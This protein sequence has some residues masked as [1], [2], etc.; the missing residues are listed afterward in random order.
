MYEEVAAWIQWKCHSWSYLQWSLIVCSWTALGFYIARYSEIARIDN[1]FRQTRGQVYIDLQ[2]LTSINATLNS[3]LG[4]CCFFASM[5][6]LSFSRYARRL[7]IFGDAL[8]SATKELF[9]FTCLFLVMFTAFLVLFYLLFAPKSLLHTLQMLVKLILL[10]LD[11]STLA[12]LDDTRGPFCLA[13]F[14]F[15]VVFIGMAMFVSII[16][17]S[18]RVAQT[19]ARVNPKEDSDMFALLW[20]RFRGWTGSFHR[21]FSAG[22]EWL[23]LSRIEKVRRTG[24]LRRKRQT[25]AVTI[26]SSGR[27]AVRED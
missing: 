18:F 9:C 7:S 3:L 11:A 10:K 5:K 4:F 6:L 17:G 1:F 19:K 15:F 16:S 26:S 23:C 21:F 24:S 12:S 8:R 27:T 13:L 14:I 2:F 25:N 22:V 20:S